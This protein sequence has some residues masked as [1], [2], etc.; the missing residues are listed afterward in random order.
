MSA[1]RPEALAAFGVGV[2]SAFGAAGDGAADV[3]C[4]GGACFRFLPRAG[5]GCRE[6]GEGASLC[7]L[8]G[9]TPFRLRHLPPLRRGRNSAGAFGVDQRDDAAFGNLVADL[10]PDLL[11]DTRDRRRHLHR[12]L[13]RFER[14]E[15]LILGHRVARFHEH[16]DDGDLLVIADVGDFDFDRAMAGPSGLIS[17]ASRRRDFIVLETGPYCSFTAIIEGVSICRGHGA[18]PLFAA[19]SAKAAAV[20]QSAIRGVLASVRSADSALHSSAMP[21]RVVVG[22]RSLAWSA[23]FR[24]SAKRLP[25]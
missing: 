18:V 13:V 16:F 19:P 21:L 6:R 14:D 23:T 22:E 15:A 12:R 3:D 24:P 9:F 20:L 10:D 5:E 2:V 11:D 4:G 7:T 25:A 1:L 17:I 8:R